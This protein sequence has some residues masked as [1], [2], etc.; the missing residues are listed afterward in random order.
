MK[1]IIFILLCLILDIQC[2]NANQLNG[3]IAIGDESVARI[4]TRGIGDAIDIGASVGELVLDIIKTAQQNA[5]KKLSNVGFV[6]GLLYK[7]TY[8]ITS[9]TG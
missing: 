4:Q 5:D 7:I 9:K 6:K 2:F 1:F 3:T 8:N